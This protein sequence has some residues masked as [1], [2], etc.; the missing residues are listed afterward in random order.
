MRTTGDIYPELWF[1]RTTGF[2]TLG[3]NNYKLTSTDTDTGLWIEDA[4]VTTLMGQGLSKL[5]NSALDVYILDSAED[6]AY[7]SRISSY[8]NP[9]LNGKTFVIASEDP[10]DLSGKYWTPIN[11]IASKN[12]KFNIIGVAIK[13]TDITQY[14][15][16]EDAEVDNV[17]IHGMTI[18]DGSAFIELFSDGMIQG[19]DF[20]KT[21]VYSTGEYAANFVGQ[22]HNSNTTT[23]IDYTV[24]ENIELLTRIKHCNFVSGAI[25]SSANN[26][27]GMV[28][29]LGK[30]SLIYASSVTGYDKT[31]VEPVLHE[32]ENFGDDYGGRIQHNLN[33]SIAGF[34]AINDGIIQ[35]NYFNGILLVTSQTET[36][37]YVDTNNFIITDNFVKG[38]IRDYYLGSN[39]HNTFNSINNNKSILKH[40]YSAVVIDGHNVS[41]QYNRFV[42]IGTINSGAT[43]I[44][45][46]YLIDTTSNPKVGNGLINDDTGLNENQL[47]I[48]TST[49]LRTFTI[50][51]P[52]STWD[53]RN[54]WTYVKEVNWN[55]PVLR[56]IYGYRVAE[57]YVTIY[58]PHAYDNNKL[59]LGN[60][61]IDLD[62]TG[63][64]ANATTGVIES[65]Y[66]EIIDDPE[67]ND[68]TVLTFMY[69]VTLNYVTEIVVSNTE[70]GLI[71]SVLWGQ[72]IPAGIEIDNVLVENEST[73][74]EEQ[75]GQDN[76]DVIITEKI[77][78][79]YYG[80]VITFDERI[81]NININTILTADPG[82]DGVLDSDYLTVVLVHTNKTNIVDYAYTVTMLNG[83]SITL[84]DIFNG[85][86]DVE[87]ITYKADIFNSEEDDI[88]YT[89]EE[90]IATKDEYGSWSLFIY[91]PMFYLN[92]RN[93]TVVETFNVSNNPTIVRLV[94]EHDNELYDF[95]DTLDSVVNTDYVITGTDI[96]ANNYFGTF[97]LDT[98]T[99][100]VT[101][102]ISLHKPYEYWL[103]ASASNK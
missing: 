67:H 43:L 38:L 34:V 54:I 6:L 88:Q 46:Y 41:T 97:T 69:T 14:D 44:K 7:L 84:D 102:N 86:L 28:G 85:D 59:Q 70:D 79:D 50:F 3:L 39:T 101:I 58:N 52:L 100:D 49:Q 103:H 13:S 82:T 93:N 31:Q 98:L 66:G 71:S 40:N 80:L 95:Y 32:T 94:D 74:Y 9:E 87:Y 68:T 27:A 48:I 57:I 63:I 77:I 83:Q 60:L 92:D 2:E 35:E 30:N 11:S 12:N 76:K 73:F 18:K 5:Y 21:I 42:V 15:I 36:S 90:R 19:I 37:G 8:E 16:E 25:L 53:F 26:T 55:Y 78:H 51:S 23:D 33:D 20:T 24:E 99:R 72:K 17:V 81:F 62:N 64:R 4:A 61:E 56:S 91:Y 10:I 75:A 22:M 47:S 29:Y 65:P 1:E 45:N 89:D 96:I